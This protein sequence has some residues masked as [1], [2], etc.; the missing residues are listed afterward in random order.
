MSRKEWANT[1]YA[2]ATILMMIRQKP[3]LMI[4]ATQKGI[5][6]YIGWQTDYDF[7]PNQS[8]FSDL[9]KAE[10]FFAVKAL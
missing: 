3:D 10:R 9:G 2:G 4:P 8:D 1:I 6:E 5:A 7:S